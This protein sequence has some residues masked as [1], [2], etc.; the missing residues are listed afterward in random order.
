MRLLVVFCVYLS[1]QTAFL[2]DWKLPAS[3]Q[4]FIALTVNCSKKT[5]TNET[6]KE[7]IATAFVELL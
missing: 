3:P 1:A 2:F 5:D 4:L 7:L 6:F